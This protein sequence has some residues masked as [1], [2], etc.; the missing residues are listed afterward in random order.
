MFVLKLRALRAAPLALAYWLGVAGSDRR[1]N[2]CARILMLH[3]VARR[4]ARLFER[5]VRYVKRSFDIVPLHSIAAD[6]A[7]GD[8]RFRRQLAITFD[9]GLRNNVDMAYPILKAH[10]A[11]ATFFVC[12]ELIDQGRWLW[13]HEARQRLSRLPPEARQELACELDCDAG[14]E[15]IIHRMKTL[16]LYARTQAEARIRAATAGFVPRPAE[17]HQFDLAGWDELRRL[18]PGVVTIGSHTLTH[19]ILPTLTEAEAEREIA[20]SRRILEARL[21]RPVETFAYPNG[22]ISAP[23]LDCVR[24]TYR[25]AVSTDKGQVAPGADPHMLPRINV[26]GSVLKLAVALHR[27]H[28][29]VTPTSTSGS[30]VA[31]CGNTVIRAMHSTIMKKNGNEASAT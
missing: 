3:G 25:A 16:P 29:T 12:P 14:V 28:F 10:G 11:T 6:A 22:N 4:D 27:D 17:R 31:S 5:V 19:P 1:N 21:Q 15:S 30:Q 2:G 8:V 26:P 9:D 23:V 24:K 13:N 7:A 20:E 18:D